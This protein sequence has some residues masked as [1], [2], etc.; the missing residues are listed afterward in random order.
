V[1]FW[2]RI[3]ADAKQ[4]WQEHKIAPAVHG[5]IDPRGCADIDGDGDVDVVRTDIWFENADGK[6]T[7][8][9][10]HKNI[11]FGQPEARFPLMTKSWIVDLDKDGDNDIVQAEGDCE[12]GRL[13]WH[14][15][16]DGKGR[17]F[18]RHLLTDKSGQ[19]FHSLAVADFDN[20]GDL[21]VFSGG[22]P[23]TKETTRRWFIWENTDSKGKQWAQHEIL[24]SKKC[25]EAKAADVDGDGDID[26]CSKPWNGNEHIY[27]CNLL[28]ENAAK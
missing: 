3:P 22:G 8:W 9:V 6:G 13:A 15:N 7:I 2:Y 12:S 18:V 27:L 23:L 25:H 5:A 20:D 16:K 17:D 19:D 21:D 11:D 14:E 10:E 4:I 1:M 24:S 26:I 28:M